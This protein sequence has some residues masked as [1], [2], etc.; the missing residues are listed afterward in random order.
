MPSVLVAYRRGG[1]HEAGGRRLSRSSSEMGSMECPLA[2]LALAED[3]AENEERVP[4]VL[5]YP[6]SVPMPGCSRVSRLR[7]KASPPIL[8]VRRFLNASEEAAGDTARS[9]PPFAG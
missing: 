8:G 1:G 4:A 2:R 9:L 5:L 7:T 3:K 6:G